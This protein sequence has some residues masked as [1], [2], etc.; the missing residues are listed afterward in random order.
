MGAASVT[1]IEDDRKVL[2]DTGHFGNRD[3]L[4]AGLKNA[5]VEPS[6]IDAVLITHI[7][8]DHCLNTD[9]FDSAEIILGRKEFEKGTLTG[10]DDGLTEG[11]IHYISGRRH[12]LAEDGYRVSANSEVLSTPG[13]TPG[14]IALKVSDGG[15]L[16]ILS[17]DSVPNLRAYRRGLPDFVFHNL[18]EARESVARIRKLKPDVIIPGHDPP[19]NDTG[20]LEHDVID[21]ILRNVD[22]TDTVFTLNRTAAENPVIHRE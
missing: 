16:I 3:A 8:W 13:H 4:K 21:I 12:V 14:H 10:S 2:V 1:L 6:S 7:N 11:F 20:Y 9:M 22:E 15:R 18:Q 19:F 17:G 5:G